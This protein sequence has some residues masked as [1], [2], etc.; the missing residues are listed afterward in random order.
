VMIGKYRPNDADDEVEIR[1][2]LPQSERSLDRFDALKLRTENGQVPIANFVTREARPKVSSI[3]RKDGLYAMSVKAGVDQSDGTTVDQKVGEL[4]ALID[5][6]SWPDGIFFRFRG[7]DEEQKESGEFL[8]RAMLG[9]LFLMFI[10]LV[11]QFNSFY[12]TVI[13][14]LTVILAAAGALI[15][16]VV[17]GQKFSIIMTGTGIIAL[18]GIV[19]NNAIVLIDT[20]N[21]MRADGAEVRDA[22]LKTAAQRLRPILLTTITTIAGLIP[23]ATQVN[24][25][26][27]ERTISVGGITSVWWVQLSTAVIF[28]LA[29]STILTLIL[30]PVLLTLPVNANHAYVRNAARIGRLTAAA[31]AMVARLFQRGVPAAEPVPV[32]ANDAE[33][34]RQDNRRESAQ[35]YK[36]PEAAE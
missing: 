17:T 14:L 20:Y 15:G 9:S 8:M 19:V 31:K 23:M 25:N 18:A 34:V 30:V 16:M 35:D 12:Q 28:G 24:F 5:Q 22:V 32:A 11:T 3:T 21:R 29:F 33:P 13:T 2:R 1:V 4:Q 26:F 6:Q 27:F 10:I 36:M 7:A